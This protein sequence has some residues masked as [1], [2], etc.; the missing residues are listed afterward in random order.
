MYGQSY[1]RRL[2]STPKKKD[3]DVVNRSRSNTW[4]CARCGKR[5]QVHIPD[6]DHDGNVACED[7][8]RSL[9][10]LEDAI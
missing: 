8:S 7:C 10:T 4:R 6:E 1:I 3:P 2:S 5:F 9:Q